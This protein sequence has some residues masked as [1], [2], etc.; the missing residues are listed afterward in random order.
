MNL[1][2]LNF[3]SYKEYGDLTN[4][5][6]NINLAGG[7]M[8]DI[9]VYAL[10]LMRLFMESQPAEVVSLG[11]LAS[12]GVDEAGGIVCR[13]GQGQIGVV[14]LTLHSKQPKRAVLSFDR[15]YVEV[16]DYPRADRATIVWTA[17]GRR[18]EVRAGM[19]GYALCYE[20]AD[21]EAAVAGDAERARLIDYAADVMALMDRLRADWGVVYPEESSAG[22]PR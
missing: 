6:Y 16:M 9:G 20:L 4:R 11:N 17:D 13:N 1:A 10:S 2:Q 18:E 12:T 22:V 5:F 7:A 8:L 15:C 21:L 3:G 14:S 19:E